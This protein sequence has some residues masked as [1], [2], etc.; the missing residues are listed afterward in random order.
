RYWLTTKQT[1]RMFFNSAK[2]Q[3]AENDTLALVWESAQ[4]LATKG[5]FEEVH[6]V[7]Q[8]TDT[9]SVN[10]AASGIDSQATR[11]VVLDP[12]FWTLLNG[13]DGKSRSDI[14][15]IFGIGDDGLLVDNAASCVIAAVNT[16]QRR[17]AIQASQ[18][19]LTWRFVVGQVIEEDER[20]DVLRKLTE[21]ESR[22]KEKVRGAYRHYVYLTR[23]GE[24]LEAV[25]ARFEDEKQTTLNGSEVGSALVTANRAVGEHMDTREKGRK[26]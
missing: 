9:Q 24:Q 10:D 16:Y 23:K 5:Q 12:R 22:L 4:T 7:H 18:E 20:A 26:R 8:P 25:F 1:L 15:R 14:R 19:V 6:F 11:L 13:D 17:H 21:A 3:I 2:S